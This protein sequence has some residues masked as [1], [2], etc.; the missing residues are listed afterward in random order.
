MLLQSLNTD[1]YD[2]QLNVVVKGSVDL[3][4]KPD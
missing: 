3:D 1:F 2:E 4:V